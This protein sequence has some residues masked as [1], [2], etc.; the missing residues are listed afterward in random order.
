[1]N[2]FMALDVETA[3][4]DY[5]SI[6]QIGIVEHRNGDQIST[7][8]TLI[9]PE[10]FFD[11]YNVEIHGVGPDRV[12]G[13]PT[14]GEAFPK[15]SELLTRKTVVHHG[16]FDRTAFARC[17]DLHGLHPL[18]CAWLDSTKIVRRAWPEFMQRGYGL[19][20]LARHFAITLD[21]HDALSDAAAA[22]L[23]V[24]RALVESGRPLEEWLVAVKRPISGP[25]TSGDLRRDGDPDA[26]FF[27]ESIVF[28]GTLSVAKATAADEAQ[29]LGFDV[30]NG[31]TKK[32]T[33]LC[34]GI[35]DASR[36]AGYSKSSK[37]R[38]AEKLVSEG[39]EI[40]ILSEPDFWALARAHQ[41]GE[42]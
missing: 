11:P 20:N 24:E 2:H 35:Q 29:K 41:T 38:K 7:W 18:E 42:F 5:S 19:K 30:Q 8:S 22:A 17:Y 27:G 39:H 1:M 37:H 34:V 12:K 21:H 36:L 4:A 9:D 32:T 31:V 25:H 33:F 16:H 13:A 10:T 3:N 26:P 15:L 23:I 14:F 28:T 40:S 6:C